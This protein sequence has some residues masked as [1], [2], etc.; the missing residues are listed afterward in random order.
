MITI[1]LDVFQ[2]LALSCFGLVLGSWLRRRFSIFDDLNI[3]VPILGGLIY[4][5]ASLALRGSVNFEMDLSLQRVLMVAFFTSVG[6]GA[7]VALVRKGGPQVLLFLVIATVGAALQNGLGVALA[8]LF[9]LN[10]LMGIVSGSVAL[11]GGPATALSFGKTFEALGVTGATTLG[12]S[13][14]MFGMTAGGLLGGFIGGKIIR[15][16]QLHPE[17]IG[18]EERA[19]L[20]P[21]AV[22]VDVEKEEASLLQNIVIIGICMGL[23]SIIGGWFTARQIVLPEYVGAMIV[24]AVVR[25]LDDRFHIAGVSQRHADV[26]GN[27]ALSLFIVMAMLGLRLWELA[28]LATPMV[29]MLVLQVALIWAMCLGVFR[30]MG[31]DYEAAVMSGGFCGFMLGT[32][33]NAVACM[34]V[35]TQKYGPAP[36]SFIVVPLVGASLIDFTNAT[37]INAMTNLVR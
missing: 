35:L 33:A 30:V 7:S 14:A 1:K 27:I 36:R 4:A 18:R 23:G 5:L 12:V 34:S 31:R 19:V 11:T 22:E 2:V 8:K 17:V 29:V 37:I 21:V 32:T 3:P 10:P 25:N 24:A 9:G 20:A 6:L 26:I 13:C 15:G 28:H 16:R